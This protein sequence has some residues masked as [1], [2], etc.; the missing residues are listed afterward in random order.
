MTGLIFFT[1]IANGPI[2]QESEIWNIIIQL[3]C[4]LRA[5]HQAN[6]ACRCEIS[7]RDFFIKSI[8]SCFFSYR[9]LDPTKIITDEKR[10]R[11]SFV[12]ITDIVTFDPN[13]QNPFQLV[14]HYQ[15]VGIFFKSAIIS[16]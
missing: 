16:F 7:F 14:N 10:L 9:T 11:F 8:N 13:Q 4:G 12:G 2:L 3:T 6:L 5:I 15:Q 1:Y